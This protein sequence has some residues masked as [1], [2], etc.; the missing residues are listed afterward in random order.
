[1]IIKH[2][3]D[4]NTFTLTYLVY[5][6]QSKDAVIID[7][8]LDFDYASGK[9]SKESAENIIKTIVD[10]RLS[11][12]MIL[13]THPHADHMSSAQY[14]KKTFPNSRTAIGENV[15]I[16][17]ETFRAL[18]N[19]DASFKTDGS[20][21]DQLL[22]EGDCIKAG[23]LEFTVFS[24]PGH[25]PACS[26]YLFQDVLFTGDALFMPDFGT[27]RC[28]FPN[29]S[30]EALY[31]SIHE[32]LYTLPDKTRV[33]VGHDYMPNGRAL[34][35]MSTIKNEKVYNIHLKARTSKDEFVQLRRERDSS[36]NAPK[37]LLPSLQVNI[38]G[39]HLPDKESNGKR[40]LK[41]PLTEF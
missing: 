14:L 11:V 31:E 18:Y 19:L 16:V 6:E 32:K 26:S 15:K 1:M 13:E 9:V 20:Q 25:T 39:G 17:Q 34:E 22:K 12:K 33:F 3:F 36:L 24:T 21:F 4:K 5:D 10:L 8:V 41:L 7:P 2:F 35:F 30:A 23:T 28:D 40:Y 29:G 27:G 38:N 37:L